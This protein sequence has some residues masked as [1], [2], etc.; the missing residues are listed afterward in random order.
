MNPLKT[1]G[2][3]M[4]A[5]VILLTVSCGTGMY[6]GDSWRVFVKKVRYEDNFGIAPNQQDGL[7]IDVII[8]YIGPDG[9]V[10]A[11]AISLKKGSEPELKAALVQTREND[12]ASDL[13]IRAWLGDKETKFDMKK[14]DTLS[15]AP[16]SLLWKMPEQRGRFKLLIGD[17]PPITV[18]L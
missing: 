1:V 17:V 5:L 15:K 8:E 10:L 18:Y 9:K 14:G 7:V 4:L 12:P 11:P 3:F 2:T 16:L 13:I 6:E